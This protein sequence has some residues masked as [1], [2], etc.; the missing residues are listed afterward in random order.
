MCADQQRRGGILLFKPLTVGIAG[1]KSIPRASGIRRREAACGIAFVLPSLVGCLVFVIIP[2][3]EALRR[4][5]TSGLQNAFVGFANYAEIF[6]NASFRQAAVNTLRFIALCVPMLLCASLGLALLLFR[7]VHGRSALRAAFLLPM[8]IPAASVALLWQL[9]FH[10]NGVIGGLLTSLGL[11]SIDWMRTDWSLFCLI[12]CYVWK[13]A[14]YNMVL[15]LAG[16]GGI[17]PALYEAAAV[18]GAGRFRQFTAI[19]WPCLRPTLFTVTVLSL[20]NTF[21]AYRE[22][23]LVAGNY[24]QGSI[25]LLQHTLNNWFGA[26]EIEKLCAAATVTAI[27]ILGLVALLNRAWGLKAQEEIL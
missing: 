21:K 18:D 4:S 26:L 2:F 25:Y 5:F 16:L 22:A 17:S 6:Q 7:P 9:L 20:L 19:T 23:W 11:Q 10:V 1:T 14:G 3:G 27:I 13:N 24:P 12:L 15:F 8:A